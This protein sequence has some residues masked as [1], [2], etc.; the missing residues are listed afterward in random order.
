[1][2]DIKKLQAQLMERID[3]EDL[4]QVEK[5]ERYIALI[6]LNNK[7]DANIAEDGT[8]VVVVN[9]AQEYIKV[10]PAIAEK[11]KI[12]SSLLAIEKS[13]E[14]KAPDLPEAEEPEDEPK[15]KKKASGL[16]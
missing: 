6:K 10:H 5:V 15:P 7:L 16:L 4:Q 11:S 2:V 9:G 14:F 8:R 3:T 13:F 12:N 1:M